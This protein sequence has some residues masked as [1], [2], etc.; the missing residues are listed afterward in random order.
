MSNKIQIKRSV[1]N[2][3]VSGLSNGELAF[4][5]ASNTLWIGLPDGSGV[6]SIAGQRTPGTLTAN[7]A[8]V[9]NS[10]SGIDKIIVANAVVTTLTANG[11]SGG[12][13]D[14]LFSNGSVAYWAPS[15]AISV[16]TAAQYSWTNT[17]TF[18]QT[19]NGTAN[20]ALYLNS[21]AEADLNVNNALTSNNASYLNSKAE[22]DLNV[23]SALSSNNSSYLNNKAE[24]DLNVN[25]ALYANI[26]TYVL[27]NSGIVSNSSGVFVAAGDGVAVNA[28]GVH[29]VGNTGVTSNSSG[30]FI[31]QPVAT[32]DNVTFNDIIINGNT[33]LGDST[34]D[35]IAINGRVNTSII[36]AANATYDL[37][38]AGMAWKDLYL[39]GSSIKLGS[40]TLTDVSGALTT[41][42]ITAVTDLTSQNLTINGNTVLGDSSSD[43]V[44]VVASVNTNIMPSAN[45]TYNIGNNTIRWN[46]IHA[47]NIHSVTGKF[48]GSVEIAGNLTVVGNVTTV[49]VQSVIVSDP[50]IYL[51]GNNYSSDLVDI[52]LAGN[53]NDGTNRHTGLFRDHVD[54]VWKLFYNLT[55]ELDAN[56]DIDT[57]DPTYRIATL[58]AYLESGGLTTNSSSA[59]IS[60]NSTWSVNIVANTLSLSSP[61]AGNSGGTGLSSYTAEDIL[62]ANSSNGFR[63]LTLG[64]AGYV[65]Q[66]N[67]SALVY[68]TLDGGTF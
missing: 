59:N 29:V 46:E 63:K 60:A 22:A 5:Q 42:N 56:N 27:A 33:S 50:L 41:N 11:S 47:A 16:N 64:T 15:G 36:P 32:T 49:N 52:G 48:D 7:Q 66:S 67:G 65:L 1:A 2:G 57:S 39:S 24:A 44:S 58:Q 10:T 21:K 9:A 61:L 55:Q 3:T 37:G 31:G 45:A 38:S 19:I 28:T 35:V 14:I 18:S 51:A 23:N 40:I 68:D 6:V 17:H 62:V 30:V 25:N 8:L 12:T 54:G 13:G 43:V 4:T 53:Y 26:A 20:N 34:S